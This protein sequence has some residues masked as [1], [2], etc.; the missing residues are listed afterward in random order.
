MIEII[1]SLKLTDEYWDCE[2]KRDF[3]HPRSDDFCMVCKAER[4]DQPD[5][6]VTEVL[7]NGLTI[8]S[9]DIT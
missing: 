2:C 7:G 9:S 4:A 8:K 3:I 5:S 6:H 1:G